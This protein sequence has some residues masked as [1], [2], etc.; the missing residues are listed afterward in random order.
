MNVHAAAAATQPSA[1]PPVVARGSTDPWTPDE[2][3]LVD[4]LIDEFGDS[5]ARATDD[6]RAAVATFRAG[7]ARGLDKARLLELALAVNVELL[8]VRR[9]EAVLGRLRTERSALAAPARA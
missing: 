5:H 6:L 7:L 1:R 4:R 3:P 8:A 9:L 2:L